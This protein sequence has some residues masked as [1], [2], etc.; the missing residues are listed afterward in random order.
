MKNEFERMW[1]KAVVPYLEVLSRRFP[2]GTEKNNDEPQDS[3]CGR[4]LVNMVKHF[5]VPHITVNLFS[6]SRTTTP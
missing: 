5:R 4:D 6:F 2:G 3:W 1:K